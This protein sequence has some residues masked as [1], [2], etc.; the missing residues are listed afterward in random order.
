MAPSEVVSEFWRRLEARDWDGVKQLLAEDLVVEWP[1]AHVR[2]RGR[3]NFLELNRNYPEGWSIEVLRIIAEGDTVVSEVR[4]PHPTVGPYYL[5]AI[6]DV[7]QSRIVRGREY[8]TEERFDEPAD[9]L[10]RWFEPI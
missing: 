6:Y 4:A 2:V 7:E 1:N 9:E 8:W 5:L 3:T 10:A